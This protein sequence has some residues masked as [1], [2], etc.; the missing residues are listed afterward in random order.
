MAVFV[1]WLLSLQQ[2]SSTCLRLTPATSF[3]STYSLLSWLL[4]LTCQLYELASRLFLSWR[5]TS[6]IRNKQVGVCTPTT[7]DKNRNVYLFY[8]C[9]FYSATRRRGPG[10]QVAKG[11]KCRRSH[12][13]LS[14]SSFFRWLSLTKLLHVLWFSVPFALYCL[15]FHGRFMTSAKIGRQG[16]HRYDYWNHGNLVCLT[17]LSS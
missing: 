16:D 1:V 14:L 11:K 4:S 2:C 7:V 17:F 15:S 5:F 10:L 6:I 12:G 3:P 13:I 9:N 8:F